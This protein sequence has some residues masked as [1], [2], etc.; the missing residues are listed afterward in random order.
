MTILVLFKCILSPKETNK[1]S[2]FIARCYMR[3]EK[4][5][6]CNN[7]CFMN[8]VSYYNNPVNFSRKIISDVDRPNFDD[9]RSCC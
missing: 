2:F 1:S 9:G 5:S 7:C 8:C 6:R 3:K 4:E